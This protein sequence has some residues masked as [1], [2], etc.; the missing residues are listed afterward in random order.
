MVLAV[1]KAARALCGKPSYV[2]WNK[3]GLSNSRKINARVAVNETL[4]DLGYTNFK[5]APVATRQ[6]ANNNSLAL[7]IAGGNSR[8]LQ[9]NIGCRQNEAYPT[10]G[11][12]CAAGYGRCCCVSENLDV[13]FGLG[14]WHGQPSHCE[15]HA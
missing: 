7:V 10:W 2:R 4:L 3:C 13:W 14:V 11:I 15:T 6:S 5:Q 8:K 9:C 1:V 12:G